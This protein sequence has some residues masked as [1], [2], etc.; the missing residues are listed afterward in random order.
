MEDSFY[1]NRELSWL[2]FNTRVLEE[3][4]DKTNPLLER[5]KFLAITASNM[6][7]FFMVR[8]S[9]LM[10]QK[11]A[12]IQ[13]KGPSPKEQLAAISQKV[14]EIVEK[15]YNCLNRSLLPSLEKE[16]ASVLK[17]DELNAEQKR[18]CD[19]Y[20]KTTIYPI[21]TPM[22][23]DKSRPLP[24]LNNRSLNF[25][26]ELF[27]D[28]AD[29]DETGGPAA[30]LY[31]LV[32][33]PTVV[34]RL[35]PLPD[36]DGGGRCFILLE[37]II[38]CH[39]QSVF[40]GY[41][42]RDRAIFRITRDSDLE[43]DEEDSADLLREM[44]KSV[45]RRKWGLP[46]RLEIEKKMKKSSRKYLQNLLK[47]GG[48]D[49][50][51]IPGPL[52]LTV[53]SSL[54]SA[55][56]LEGYGRLLNPPIAPQPVP[57]FF[58]R[59][60]FERIKES[61]VL[62]HHPYQTFDCVLNF[63]ERAAKDPSV[64][65]I[66]QTLY[67]VSG[68]SPIV[69]ALMAAA[70]AGKQVTVL[71]ELKARFDEEN[72]I[73]WAKKLEQSGAHV[74]YGLSGLK[75]HC[76]VCL[77]VRREDD[78][79]HRYIHL[80]T[81]NYNDSTA[82]FYTDLGYFTHS[83]ALGSDVSSMFN[84][85]TGYAKNQDFNKLFVAP[86]NMRQ[87]FIKLIER[88]TRNAAEGKKSGVTAKLNSLVDRG[89]IDA[90]YAASQAGAP[91]RLIVR[92]VCC[93]RAGIAGLSENISVHS[94]VDR[95]LE[96]S[97][98]YCFENAGNPKIYLSSADWMPRNLDRRVETA[99]PIEDARLKEKITKILNITLSDTAKLRTQKPDG[100]YEKIDRRGKELIRSQMTFQQMAED[101]CREIFEEAAP[102]L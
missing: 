52:D 43:L 101:E 82:R 83:E 7:E 36:K 77:V 59:D 67:R 68:G 21:L 27:E 17:Y 57:E 45:K 6:D 54:A 42:V 46:V 9:G 78:G 1:F 70:E 32:Q 73:N 40:S 28:G 15:Q 79:I 31:A 98:I 96:H 63:V 25:I 88:E 81:G 11:A 23:V 89:I 44:E 94:I 100:S 65:A 47:R 90:L 62:A 75:T 20:F 22:A 5:F 16:G 69:A 102:K 12:K 24:L 55:D 53:W 72:N 85:L 86:S 74:V 33:V 64:L 41:T 84:L 56:A 38:R 80:G 35:F 95:F 37:D 49:T 87:N 60:I 26:A 34:K 71:V 97:R 3:A 10:D 19:D 61:D 8:V 91:V 2:E 92:G 48:E 93:L 66:K 14:H 51:E 58:G 39:I 4:Q 13:K 50:Y 99:F 18:V 29:S 76:K 30:P